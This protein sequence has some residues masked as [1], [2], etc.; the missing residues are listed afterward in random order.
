MANR[1]Y[2]NVGLAC[3]FRKVARAGVTDSHGGV[4][5]KQEHRHWLPD[6]VTP[7]DNDGVSTLDGDFVVIEEFH[8]P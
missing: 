2:E 6:D 5:M 7:A 8:Y 4:T 3:D 1:C